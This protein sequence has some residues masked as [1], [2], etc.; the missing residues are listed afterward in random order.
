MHDNEKQ[1]LH[2]WKAI[3]QALECIA[4][5]Y[6]CRL[7][8][9]HGGKV[10]QILNGQGGYAL[11]ITSLK[12]GIHEDFIETQLRKELGYGIVFGYGA[13]D[14]NCSVISF[15]CMKCDTRIQVNR[16]SPDSVLSG[17]FCQECNEQYYVRWEEG[18]LRRGKIS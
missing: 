17:V 13:G 18:V 1:A 3:V 10:V 12:H 2:A 14:Y 5:K 9:T 7:M 15:S 8:F 4:K 11:S 16:D 6:N